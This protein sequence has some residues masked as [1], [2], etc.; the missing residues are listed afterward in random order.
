MYQGSKKAERIL[1][2]TRRTSFPRQAKK[3]GWLTI[4]GAIILISI[5]IAIAIGAW[6]AL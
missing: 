2:P 5:I 6:G 4:G 1:V 3:S